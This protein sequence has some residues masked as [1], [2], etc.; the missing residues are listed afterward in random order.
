MKKSEDP[1]NPIAEWSTL[2][3]IYI[4]NNII[5]TD[6]LNWSEKVLW[7][8]NII[9]ITDNKRLAYIMG[10]K[11]QT[12]RNMKVQISKKIKKLNAEK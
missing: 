2:P 4:P 1:D 7:S 5:E 10:F 12:I 3:G 9:G 11:V 6:H 8:L